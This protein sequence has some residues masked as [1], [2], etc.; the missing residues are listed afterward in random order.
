MTFLPNSFFCLLKILSHHYHGLHLW[1]ITNDWNG[2]RYS[3]AAI[4]FTMAYLQKCV[5]IPIYLS[6]HYR[7]HQCLL[8]NSHFSEVQWHVVFLNWHNKRIFRNGLTLSS[9]GKC[10]FYGQQYILWYQPDQLIIPTAHIWYIHRGTLS[11]KGKLN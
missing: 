8:F 10:S 4:K 2:L 9:Y 7:I 3:I 6:I 5:W 11:Q 1:L